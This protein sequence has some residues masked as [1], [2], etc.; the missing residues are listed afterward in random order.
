MARS[1]PLISSDNLG[2]VIRTFLASPPA[3]TPVEII[4]AFN[5]PGT[6]EL[7]PPRLFQ[8]TVEQAPVAISITDPDARILYA[9]AAFEALAGYR[10]VEVI[11]QKESMLSSK[12]T[13][14]SV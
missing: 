11:G 2:D 12:S 10:R 9:N 13:P 3:G 5:A 6:G 7:L 14:D 4:E 8:E 1:K